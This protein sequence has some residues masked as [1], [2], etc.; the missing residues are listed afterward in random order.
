MSSVHCH[1]P[2]GYLMCVK[3]CVRK[4]VVR[5]VRRR[6]GQTNRQTDISFV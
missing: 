4:C 2:I 1:K 6:E 3:G 5:C